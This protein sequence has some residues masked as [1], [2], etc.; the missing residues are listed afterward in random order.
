MFNL[1]KK[2]IVNIYNE[3]RFC[4]PDIKIYY[5]AMELQPEIA[6][7]QWNRMQG[8][9]IDLVYMRIQYMTQKAFQCENEQIFQ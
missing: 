9:E 5:I 2:K 8:M 7:H 1:V 6:I 3:R 4:I